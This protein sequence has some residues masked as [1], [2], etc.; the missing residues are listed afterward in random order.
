MEKLTQNQ[1]SQL[2]ESELR[3]YNHALYL[4][5]LENAGG[6]GG[7]WTDGHDILKNK[8]GYKEVETRRDGHRV[9]IKLIPPTEEEFHKSREMRE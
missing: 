3:E 6:I 8:F 1:I 5:T 7:G 2:T 9:F 4:C